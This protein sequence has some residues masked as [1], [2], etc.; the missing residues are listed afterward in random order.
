MRRKF[1]LIHMLVAAL[2]VTATVPGTEL[3][4]H[5]V[6]AQSTMPGPHQPVM[7]VPRI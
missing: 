1:S 6:V 7:P 4:P 2:V 3:D 5:G